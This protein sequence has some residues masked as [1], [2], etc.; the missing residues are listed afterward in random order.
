M[1][2]APGTCRPLINLDCQFIASLFKIWGQFKFRWSKAI[3]T[4]SYIMAVKP[5]GHTTFYTLEGYI[6]RTIFHPFRN[7]KI[8]HIGSY[9]I[10]SLRNLSRQNLLS[11]IPGILGICILGGIIAFHLNMG[12]HSDVI[13][14]TAIIILFFK[15]RNK[16]CNIFCIREFP[17]TV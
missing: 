1:I 5:Q 2:L 9:R 11:A 7:F 13:P 10:K 4:V 14:C 15:S 12:R 8:F 17:N 6:Y 16:R 3:L